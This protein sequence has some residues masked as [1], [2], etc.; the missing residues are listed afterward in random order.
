VLESQRERFLEKL[1]AT[2]V[3]DADNRLTY[4]FSGISHDVHK[5]FPMVVIAE[6]SS[7]CNLVC[8]GCPYKDL[9]REHG[10]MDF[11]LFRKVVDEVAPYGVRSWF[12]FMGEP[13]MHPRIFDMIDYA[14][15]AGLGYFGLSTN[16]LLLDDHNI[17]R[18][19]DSGL[20]RLEISI[21]SLDPEL[22]ALLR[23][24]GNPNRILK[25]AH[26][27]FE[28][29]YERGD[30]YPI[31]SV[32]RRDMME[33]QH[34]RDAFLQHWNG[35][36]EEPDFVL[37]LKWIS[38]GG[39]EGLDSATYQLP[40]TRL[41]CPKL[42]DTLLVLQDGTVVTCPP[43]WDAQAVMG[44]V[45]NSSIRDIWAGREY[46]TLRERHLTDDLEGEPVCE[47]CTDWWVSLGMV[48]YENLS[49]TS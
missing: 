1:G 16:G 20:Q 29:K 6:V 17:E 4:S 33:N 38:W 49:T 10:F 39:H 47:N 18:L 8:M 21:D 26:R 40:A 34:E 12:H 11:D 43:K 30:F 15:D 28:R 25:N 44:N 14:V 7:Y 48:T 45:T 13:L 41:P 46:V 37:G 23:P 2:I 27:Y 36:L 19:L 9:S 3:S 22:F 31:T 35:V 32:S 5:E 42:W 24:G